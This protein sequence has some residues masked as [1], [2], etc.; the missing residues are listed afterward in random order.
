MYTRRKCTEA[1]VAGACRLGSTAAWL[2]GMAYLK[3]WL[4]CR[5]LVGVIIQAYVHGRE[6]WD[7]LP[8]AFPSLCGVPPSLLP[9]LLWRAAGFNGQAHLLPGK[10]R[11]RWR[12]CSRSPARSAANAREVCQLFVLCICVCDETPSCKW[13][14]LKLHQKLPVAGK[15]S[16]WPLCGPHP[17]GAHWHS[18]I[19]IWL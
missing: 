9:H 7:F 2:A 6:G 14:V 10:F 11:I 12:C 13:W 17:P 8:T 15:P 18:T 1:H 3:C 5:F 4:N 16:F 19:H